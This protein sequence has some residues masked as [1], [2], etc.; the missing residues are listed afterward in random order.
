MKEEMEVERKKAWQC[1][2]CDYIH[3]GSYPPDPCPE[4]GAA[5][6]EFV[7]YEEE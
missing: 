4:C 1:S 2:V 6:E 3:Y 5:S 7:P